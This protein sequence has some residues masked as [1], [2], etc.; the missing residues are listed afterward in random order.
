MN[1]PS[2]WQ[3][4][5]WRSWALLPL[6]ALFLLASF[7]RR[8]FA[9]PLQPSCPVL[10]VGNVTVGG[11]GKTPVAIDLARRFQERGENVHLLCRGYGGRLSGPVLVDLATHD[12]G[13]VGDEALL[14]A[15]AAP[16]WAAWDREAGAKAAAAAGA[17]LI[18]LD[19]GLQN[20]HLAKTCS[21]L[22]ID[23]ETGFGNGM[24][25]PAG[26][27]REPVRSALARVDAVVIMGQPKAAALNRLPFDKPTLQ[28]AIVPR[29]DM[30][31]RW[32]ERRV[33]AF[34]GIGRPD[35]FFTA[36]TE[37]GSKVVARCAYPDHHR[38]DADE[39]ERIGSLAERHKAEMVTTVKDWVRLPQTWQQRCD[40]LFVNVRWQD[41]EL[42]EKLLFHQ[43]ADKAARY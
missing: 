41:A 33:V 11:T 28:A 9:Q 34:A 30:V 3:K 6:S 31:D 36:L 7:L 38:F 16:T 43:A 20:P 5:D 42:L 27:L 18:I 21:L 19:D 17:S 37:L 8:L 24:V 1:P 23:G 39:L 13:D 14:L 35:K 32:A 2:F 15:Q 12:A 40:P 29:G 25:L 4:A 22:V 26:P 10:C